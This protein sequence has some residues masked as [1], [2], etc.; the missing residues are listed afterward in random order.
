MLRAWILLLCL[1]L[2][3]DAWALLWPSTAE[4]IE[5]DLR[6]RE[7]EAR[8]EAARRIP[9]LPP[10]LARRA[11]WLAMQD[12]DLR[13]RLLAADAAIQLRLA[14]AGDRVVSWLN[15]P[16]HRLRR[17]A[18]EVLAEV[19]SEHGVVP[20]GRALSDV[21]A[22]VRTAAAEALGASGRKEATP[23]LLGHLDDVDPGVSEAVITSLARLGD[24]AAV[25]PLIGKVQDSRPA[26]RMS[27]VRALGE[28]GDR[29]AIDSLL[30]AL[31]DPEQALVGEAIRALGRLRADSAAL[32]IIAVMDGTPS[33][34]VQNAAVQALGQIGTEAGTMRLVQALGD[35]RP[36]GLRE[37]ARRALA[38]MGERALPALDRCLRGQPD[39]AR[40]D[41]CVLAAGGVKAPGA[42]KVVIDALQRAVVTPQAALAAL[43]ELGDPNALPAVLEALVDPD[44]GVR[45]AAIEA[46]HALLDPRDP[47]GRAIEPIV[48]AL[49]LARHRPEEC[50][51]LAALL[52][53][54]GSPRAIEPLLPLARDA[55]LLGVRVAAVTALGIVPPSGQ[56]EVLLD[57]LTDEEHEVRFAAA[58]ALR[59]AA[60]ASVASRL[61][62][63]LER[64][65]ERDRVAIGLALVGALSRSTDA[66][67]ARRVDRLISERRG[68]ER[69]ALIEALG[70][71][72]VERSVALLVSRS[73]RAVDPADRRKIAEALAG[74]EQGRR[75]LQV[76]ARDRD[77]SVRANALWSWGTVARP[78]DAPL[79]GRALTDHDAAVAGNAAAALGRLAVRSRLRVRTLLCP[80]LRDER[81]YVR[82]NALAALRLAAERCDGG[83]ERDLLARDRSEVVR[84]AAARLLRAVPD[85]SPKEGDRDTL[86]RCEYHDSVAEVASACAGLEITGGPS[87]DQ[88]ATE[89]ALVY[90]VQAGDSSP[91][92]EAAF[93]LELPDGP[94]R[95]GFTDRRGAVFE[96]RVPRG[97]LRLAVPAPLAP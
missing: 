62:A 9:E 58:V 73:A 14:G 33:R 17:V 54:T 91:T 82:A 1:L 38:G 27:A 43:G 66:A 55:N 64:E 29:R 70:R 31:Q 83:P 59:R 92:P 11:T 41:G 39:L 61:L 2:T 7:V 12:E 89:N 97:A 34:T 93:A 96:A 40:A 10:R 23:A 48:Q 84:L 24:A 56:D 22:E 18:A 90:V 4:R 77:A 28:L 15:D 71:M 85:P 81:S 76:L 37:G 25:A 36:D 60:S 53:R 87:R 57:A 49:R 51:R 45:G 13:V 75:A 26:V 68:G 80:A 42:V 35:S 5:Q 16:E 20:L 3:R 21:E 32:P 6:A 74:R 67:L 47:D 72:P 95:L 65:A 69:D 19:P 46:T 94:M 63:A 30:L 44:P 86:R 79:L 8:R 78:E 50:A 52:G 88:A